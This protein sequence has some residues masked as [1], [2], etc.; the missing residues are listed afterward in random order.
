MSKSLCVDTHTRSHTLTHTP[1]D[2][3]THLHTSTHTPTDP[4]THGN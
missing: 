3:D 2:P 1:T 4:D